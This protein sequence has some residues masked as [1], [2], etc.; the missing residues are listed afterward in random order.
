MNKRFSV[1]VLNH[2]LKRGNRYTP[3][4]RCNHINPTYLQFSSASLS[5]LGNSDGGDGGPTNSNKLSSEGIAINEKSISMKMKEWFGPSATL[6]S[7]WESGNQELGNL[8][9]FPPLDYATRHLIQLLQELETFGCY[10][11][12]EDYVTLGRCKYVLKVL[13]NHH[14]RHDKDG[15]DSMEQCAYRAQAILQNMMVF[16]KKTTP[17]PQHRNTSVSFVAAWPAPDRETFFLVMQ[18]FQ[19]TRKCKDLSFP[20]L[21]QSVVDQ[22]QSEFQENNDDRFEPDSFHWNSVLICWTN[23]EDWQRAVYAATETFQR[24]THRDASSFV[25]MMLVCTDMGLN[26]HN[27]DQ[28]KGA[29]LGAQVAARLWNRYISRKHKRSSTAENDVIA[30]SLQEESPN[31]TAITEPQRD[32]YDERRKI[33]KELPSR[34]YAA[35]LQAIRAFPDSTVL[36]VSLYDEC[37]DEACLQGRVNAVVLKEFIIHAQSEAVKNK[38]LGPYLRD[39]IGKR[40][41]EAVAQLMDMVPSQW[42]ARADKNR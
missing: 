3:G 34:F 15:N 25:H 24:S 8:E 21:A 35:F 5:S 26:K 12:T 2:N 28:K 36:R 37:F 32:D 31:G 30:S 29:E 18:I 27:G 10:Y 17:A 1:G 42:T 20:R 39:I 11:Q 33:V 22:M 19:R 6:T 16:R 41:G 13:L 4:R 7:P 14:R 38:H 40:P 23:C 9:F